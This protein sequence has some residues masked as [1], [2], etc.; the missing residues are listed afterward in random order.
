[1][2][3]TRTTT[4]LYGSCARAALFFAAFVA[5]STLLACSSVYLAAASPSSTRRDAS[6]TQVR[7]PKLFE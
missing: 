7:S 5:V 1:M 4:N 6:P 2:N 3:S